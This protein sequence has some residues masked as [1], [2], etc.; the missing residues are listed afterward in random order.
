MLGL[1]QRLLGSV[2]RQ[3]MHAGFRD[4]RGGSHVSTQGTLATT[5]IRSGKSRVAPIEGF[6]DRDPVENGKV[7]DRIR[8]VHRSPKRCVGAA[9]VS[10]DSKAL[11]AEML[12]QPDAVASLGALGGASVIWGVSGLGGPAEAAQV[13]TDNSVRSGKERS[14]FV[15]RRVGPRMPVQKEHRRPGASVADPKGRL[16]QGDYFEGKPFEHRV[17]PEHGA[18][19]HQ[20]LLPDQTILSRASPATAVFT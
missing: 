18:A 20:T 2:D 7:C 13:R 8:V 9:V 11:E 5:C 14:H 10:D 15:P 3:P 4:D 12:H 6:D 16:G 1:T 19:K 17:I